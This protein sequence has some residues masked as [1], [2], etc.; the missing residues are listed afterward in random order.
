[1]IKL[2]IKMKWTS[3]AMAFILVPMVAMAQLQ[4]KAA[5]SLFAPAPKHMAKA[6]NSSSHK[7]ALRSIAP[8]PKRDNGDAPTIYGIVLNDPYE[9]FVGSFKAEPDMSVENVYADENL[10]ASGAAVYALGNLYVNCMEQ[11][12]YEIST[13]QYVFDTESWDLVDVREDLYQASSAAC[14]AYDA[15]TDRIYGIFYDDSGTNYMGFGYTTTTDPYPNYIRF[16]EEDETPMVMA[17]SPEGTIYAID[18]NGLFLTINKETG[19]LTRIGHTDV[20]PAYMQDAVIDPATGRFYWA[21]FTD[22]ERGGLFEVNTATGEATLISYFPNNEEF[23][24]LYIPDAG[25]AETAPADITDLAVNFEGASLTGQVTYTIPTTTVGGDALTGPVTAYLVIDGETYQMEAQPGQLCTFDVTVRNNGEYSAMAYI[26]AEGGQS[27]K[28]KLTVWLGYDYPKAVTNLKLTREGNTAVLTWEA[29]TIGMHGGYVNPDELNYVI[30]R[31]GFW[32]DQ[33]VGT[34]FTED[35]TGKTGNY[36]YYVRPVQHELAGEG[37]YSNEVFFGPE[38]EA[39]DVPYELFF[40]G[41]DL[42]SCIIIDANNDGTTWTYNWGGYLA[43]GGSSNVVNDDWVISPLF[44]LKAGQM[45]KLVYRAGAKMGPLYPETMEVKMGTERS[46][47]GMTTLIATETYEGIYQNIG[48]EERVQYITVEQDGNYCFGFHNITDGGNQLNLGSMVI[49]PTANISAP[50]AVTNLQVVADDHGALAATISFNAPT[51]D[52]EGNELTAIGRIDI[53]RG[54]EVIH[55]ID[56][57]TPGAEYS[58]TDNGAQLGNN[59][60][61]VIPYST[62]GDNGMDVEATVYCGVEIPDLPSNVVLTLDGNMA[63]LTWDAPTVGINGGYINPDGVIYTIYDT[64]YGNVIADNITGN[65][66]SIEA[67]FYDGVQYGLSLAIGTRNEA[68]MNPDVMVSNG[69]VVGNPYELPIKESFNRGFPAYSW[70]LMGETMDDDGWDMIEHDGADGN[71]G[72]ARFYGTA[73]WGGEEQSM[74]L[75]KVSLKGAANPVLRL[76][77]ASYFSVGDKLLIEVCDNFYGPYQVI[78]T[79][80]FDDP[81]LESWTPIEVSLAE[82]ADRDYIHL[83]FHAIPAA[84]DCNIFIDEIEVRDVLDYDAAITAFSVSDNLV[85]VGKTTADVNVTVTNR[86]VEDLIQGD[87][88]VL[89]YAGDR[90]IGTYEGR[91]LQ[92]YENWNI[93]CQYVPES[94]DPSPVAVYAL[95]EYRADQDLSNNRSD[96]YEVK[97]IK[98]ELPAVELLTAVK[99]GGN[100]MLMWSEPDLSGSPVQMVTDDFEDYIPFDINRA[101]DWTFYD[102][103]GLPTTTNYYFPG[104]EQ[105]MAYIVMNPGMVQRLVGTLADTWPA[106]SGEQYMATFCAVG[107]DNDDWMVSPELSGNAQTITFYAKSGSE[108]QGHEMFEVYYSTDDNTIESMIQTGDEVYK[109]PAGEWTMYSVEVPEGAKFFAIRCISHDRCALMIDDVTY[110]SAAHPLEVQLVGYNVYCNGELITPE[111]ITEL[112]YLIP[113][114][115]QNASYYVTAVYDLGES[116]P[117]NV[118]S[119]TSSGIDEMTLDEFKGDETIYDL[120]GREVLSPERGQVYVKKGKKFLMK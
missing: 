78:K 56:N 10:D 25:A 68:G 64:S 14:M 74:I 114:I 40:T 76:N 51:V 87:Y 60:Y 90:V 50:A 102:V 80:T 52:L 119:V 91:A 111:P 96:S 109:V 17:I 23:V 7:K 27:N 69:V 20:K 89:V 57:P 88:N 115:D 97:V 62:A 8:A 3:L 67:P 2:S 9:Y 31:T 100:T 85:E 106:H 92:P 118:V 13:T 39:W 5:R 94:A 48:Q 81:A 47:A 120:Q 99:Q 21:A 113:G 104:R 32:T 110:E 55:S 79:I 33:H 71:T 93:T 59:T 73:S 42:S 29:P 41:S 1:M 77:V 103:D 30:S 35:M 66:F 16:Y 72:Y 53:L 24:G 95:I 86:G 49:E 45:Y 108:T 82:F 54:E 112:F 98:P 105:P 46:I 12:W 26:V 37:I 34:T 43:C 4:P 6:L 15:T 44:K 11:Y 65:S 19:E 117:S 28:A 101:G 84:E 22:E 58:Y 36:Q 63:T 61:K 38:D 75:G 116:E 107:G 83:S 18:V 70:F